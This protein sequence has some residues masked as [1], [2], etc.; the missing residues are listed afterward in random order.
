MKLVTSLSRTLRYDLDMVEPW[1]DFQV[2]LRHAGKCVPS[3]LNTAAATTAGVALGF[4]LT[5]CFKPDWYPA[6]FSLDFFSTQPGLTAGG[7][8][9]FGGF[10][11][12]RNTSSEFHHHIGMILYPDK[13]SANALYNRLWEFLDVV[14]KLMI[15]TAT[16]F[17]PTYIGYRCVQVLLLK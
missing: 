1:E 8:A 4:L 5:F 2:R 10:W 17:F 9:L 6:E 3:A 13:E 7:V 11:A 15:T 12:Y 14:V 16:L